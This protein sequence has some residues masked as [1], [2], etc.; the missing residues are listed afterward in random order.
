[1]T[2]RGVV[3]FISLL[4]FEEEDGTGD[5]I[6]T[7]NSRELAVLLRSCCKFIR[8]VGDYGFEPQTLCL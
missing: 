6:E 2:H 5:K 7:A 3:K 8:G 1:M 4:G